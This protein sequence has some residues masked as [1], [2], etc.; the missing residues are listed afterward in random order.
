[1][2][3]YESYA[4]RMHNGVTKI[5]HFRDRSRATCWPMAVHVRTE[6][7]VVY[8]VRLRVDMS[9]RRVTTCMT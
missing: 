2:Q 7:P 3:I 6:S 1:M 5:K 4:V 8:V 9:T